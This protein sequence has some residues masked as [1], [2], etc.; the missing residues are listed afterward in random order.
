MKYQTS[1][2]SMRKLLLSVTLLGITIGGAACMMP[3]SK[4]TPRNSSAGEIIQDG[5]IKFTLIVAN[6]K[7]SNQPDA[8]IAITNESK[9]VFR[10]RFDSD[11]LQYLNLIV[12][13]ADHKRV[14]SGYYGAM[15]S[16]FG[17][18]RELCLKPS[19]H[20]EFNISLFAT[21][22]EK[23]RK[24]G[25]YSIQAVYTYDGIKYRSNTVNVTLK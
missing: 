3:A 15:F 9:Q 19:E 13:D 21:V 4:D 12:R 14:S 20:C 17:R 1:E 7:K 16:R 18:E 10:V 23:D 6:D 24:P 8:K 22:E 2:F 5:E 11:P 25:N